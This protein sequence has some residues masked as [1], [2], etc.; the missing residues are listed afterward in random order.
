MI[1]C[2]YNQSFKTIL[3]FKWQIFWKMLV[4]EIIT[5]ITSIVYNLINHNNIINQK[6]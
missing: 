1:L 4:L 2:N 6:S 5:H 3:L